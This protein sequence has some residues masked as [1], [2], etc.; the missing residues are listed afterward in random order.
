MLL[1]FAGFE[2]VVAVAVSLLLLLLL[3]VGA[4]AFFVVGS[5]GSVFVVETGL[6]HLH[7]LIDNKLVAVV[8]VV[9]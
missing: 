5:G 7:F 6:S 4:G 1:Y 2:V 3:E 8:V 9:V